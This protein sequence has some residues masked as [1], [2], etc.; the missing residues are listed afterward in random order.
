ML[1][2]VVWLLYSSIRP[3]ETIFTIL[4]IILLLMLQLARYLQPVTVYYMN[5]NMVS[6]APDEAQ[7]NH[8]WNVR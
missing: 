1:V 2:I 5:V 8:V 6:R 4:P 3:L 7:T